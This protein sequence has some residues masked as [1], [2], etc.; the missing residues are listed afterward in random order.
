MS[1]TNLGIKTAVVSLLGT[2]LCS[3]ASGDVDA[4][5]QSIPSIPTPFFPEKKVV[6]T[7]K[8]QATTITTNKK[9]YTDNEVYREIAEGVAR[10]GR[11]S[12]E[13][14]VIGARYN[15]EA[16]RRSILPQITPVAS[17]DDIGNVIG[18]LQ[19][20]QVIFDGGRFRA[21][22]RVLD[23]EQALAFADYAI[24][25]NERVG[26]AIDAYLQ[27]DMYRALADVSNDISARY[28]KLKSKAQ[29]RLDGGIGRKSEL[30]LFEL[31]QFEAE[32]E[33]AR[34]IAELEAVKLRLTKLA[35][36]SFDDPPPMMVFEGEESAVPPMVARAVAESQRAA[37]ELHSE[38]AERLPRI[39]LRGSVGSGTNQGLGFDDR[40]NSFSAGVQLSRPL[41]WGRDFGLK[42][43]A[44]EARAAR[45]VVE[46]ARYDAEVE[47]NT[48]NLR[49]ANLTAQLVKS[50]NLLS[51]AKARVD[52]FEEQFLGGAVTIVE[53]VGII[54][55]YR[56]IVRSQVET[57]FAL[58]SAQR[59]KVQLLGLFGPYTTSAVDQ[60]SSL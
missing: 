31:R 51:Q 25:Y 17:V 23:A 49:I 60:R 59:E 41:S 33:Q 58:L 45:A 30:S 38:R 24:Q 48:L 20:E 19:I 26:V 16:F 42:A 3:C 40:V 11:L 37:G 43:A 22:G 10:R 57:R 18:R 50:E 44:A 5:A 15:H 28:Q 32:A 29:Q 7:P 14:Q 4:P 27:Q 36:K 39:S 12:S 13:Y 8:E 54:D 56:R 2:V 21:G 6:E 9:F 52:G 47:L 53:A 1:G 35:G 46:E 34:D 55:T